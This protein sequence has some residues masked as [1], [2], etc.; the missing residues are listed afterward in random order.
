[1]IFITQSGSTY[2]VQ[3][4]SIRMLNGKHDPTPRSGTQGVF[5]VF[6]SIRGPEIGESVLIIWN[7]DVLP[8]AVDG[9]PGTLTS[10]VL[11]I[12]QDNGDN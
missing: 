12:L 5:K 2:E 11:Q 6:H 4:K 8:K 9:V 10:K 1:M 7:D 3:G